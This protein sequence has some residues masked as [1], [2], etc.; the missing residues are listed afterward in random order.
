MVPAAS[1]PFLKPDPYISRYLLISLIMG[2]N[3]IYVLVQKSQVSQKPFFRQDWQVNCSFFVRPL[4]WYYGTM[5]VLALAAKIKCHSE[6]C[7]KI[8]NCA[9]CAKMGV[10]QVRGQKIFSS[11]FY[12]FQKRKML[13]WAADA[14]GD[15]LGRN[16]S[17]M[18]QQSFKCH[19][20]SESGK[21]KLLSNFIFFKRGK[22]CA[23]RWAADAKGISWVKTFLR[24]NKK[25]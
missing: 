12:F 1:S 15:F 3:H 5:V 11:N 17:R 10:T 16:F 13:C 21:T 18:Q 24:C 23:E 14:K 25:L 19:L 7:G 22:C 4:V 2:W 20:P 8:L 6:K 9:I